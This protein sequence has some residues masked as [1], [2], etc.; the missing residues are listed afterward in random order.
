MGMKESTRTLDKI[1]L[2]LDDINNGCFYHPDYVGEGN[3]Q[4][5]PRRG[6][7]CGRCCHIYESRMKLKE[8]YPKGNLN[9][10]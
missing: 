2:L 8:I 6:V 9:G 5:E 4:L 3:P 7:M 1:S 10:F